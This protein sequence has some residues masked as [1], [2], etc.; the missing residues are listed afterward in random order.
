MEATYRE[1][2][3]DDLDDA[4]AFVHERGS[5]TERGRLRHRLSLSVRVDGETVGYGL[6][7]GEDRGRFVVEL[8]LNDAAAQAGLGQPLADTVLGKM[9]SAGVGTARVR[10]LNADGAERLWQATNWL[11]RIPSSAADEPVEAEAAAQADENAQ[12]A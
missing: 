11:D 10:S 2:R 8:A 1:L 12:A 5:T 9:Q 7:L 4:L 3:L 6:C